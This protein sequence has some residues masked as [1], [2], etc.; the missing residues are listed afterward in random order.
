MLDQCAVEEKKQN[1]PSVPRNSSTQVV[2]PKSASKPISKAHKH[3]ELLTRQEMA[4]Q[5]KYLNISRWNCV[6]RP[7]Y[8]KSC[9]ITSLT[10]C[11]NFLFSH[12]GTDVSTNQQ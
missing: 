10:A 8:Q 9:G 3:T 11:W 7:Q 4:I 6:S 2:V 1:S 12:M 5:R